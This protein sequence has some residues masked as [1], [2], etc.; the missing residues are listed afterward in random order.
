MSASG[1]LDG[2]WY[3]AAL[4]SELKAG[5]ML[6]RILIGEAMVLGR[7]KAGAPFA[8]KDVCPHRA[9]PLSGGRLLDVAGK[10]AVECPY[11]AWAFR[12]SDGTCA[13]VPALHTEEKRD[14][15]GIRTKAYALHEANGLV[16]VFHGEGAPETPPPEI[17]LPATF[18]P[19]T[20][21]IVDAAGSFDEAVIGL[22]DPA[23]T[24]TVHKQWW[25]REGAARRDKTKSY[26]PTPLGFKMP[27]HRPSAN[28]RIYKFI[29]GAPTT[30]IEFRLPALRLEHIRNDRRR[31]LGLTAMTPAEPGRTRI[32]HVIFWDFALL[33]L[34][35]PVAQ[36]MADDFLAQDGAILSLQ[37]ENLKRGAHR[38]LYFGEADEP[39]KWYLKLKRA[40][41]ER[42]EAGGFKNPLSPASLR[43]RT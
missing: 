11:H 29:G 3:L 43:W 17:G 36:S 10:T 1:I 31:I 8:L 39:A 30:E 32:A 35:R 25:W 28:T 38:P 27:A 19:K 12:V 37:N 2:L 13:A 18:R 22:V 24:P 6:R 40:W 26:E 20:V 16:W 5:A 41:A 4:S 21:T 33:D 7:T 34:I 23:H 14:A 9:A 15:S 42:A